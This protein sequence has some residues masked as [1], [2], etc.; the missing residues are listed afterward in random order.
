MSCCY[1]VPKLCPTLCG[2][3]DYI[4]P[5]S[6][7]STIFWSFKFMSI[8][9]VMLSNLLIL[10][11]PFSFNLQSFPAARSFPMSQ[12]FAS[13]GQSIAVSASSSVFPMNIQGWFLLRLTGLISLVSK[14]H[15]RVFFSTTIKKHQF[16]GAQPSL[17]TYSHIHTWLL[18]YTGLCQQIDVSAF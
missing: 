6:L 10:C 5:G 12:L 1:S 18:D 9:S 13:S 11:R 14:G 7:S 8:D 3:M 4:T 15:S 16:F 17:G 2:L